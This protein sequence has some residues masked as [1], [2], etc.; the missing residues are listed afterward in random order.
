MI[1]SLPNT[2]RQEEQNGLPSLLLPE[3]VRFIV[4]NGLG[5]AVEYPSFFFPPTKP[6]EFLRDQE[7]KQIHTIRKQY[8]FKKANDISKLVENAVLANGNSNCKEVLELNREVSKIKPYQ[9]DTSVF[10]MIHLG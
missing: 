8:A 4:E 3:E 9:F 10:T 5:R 2:P 6:C 7:Q 1:G